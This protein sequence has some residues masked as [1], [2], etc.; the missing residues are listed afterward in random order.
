LVAVSGGADSTACLHA[1]HLLRGRFA[2]ELF[3][4]GVDH[5]LRPAATDELDHAEL[6]SQSLAIPFSRTVVAVAPGGDLHRRA[7]DAR[8][9]A[10]EAAAAA[11]GAVAIATA[12]HRDDRAETVL[13]RLLHGAHLEGLGVLPL[14][15]GN[16]FR[17]LIDA[18]RADVLAHCA[19]H[20]LR[21]AEDPSNHNRRFLRARL[22]AEVLP[23]LREISPQ[24]DAHLAALADDVCRRISVSSASDS[25]L[26]A[27]ARRRIAQA[28]AGG[29][30]TV[31]LLLDGG[32]PAT[33][34]I[35]G[36]AEKIHHRPRKRRE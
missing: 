10:L 9:A 7:R 29:A 18:S 34:V 19:R 30:K 32:V 14:R 36:E 22:R 4:H 17:P 6:L 35:G 25:L 20:Q 8:Y 15:D 21:F 24:I 11:V 3:A 5:G 1:L 28:V 23:L 16:R 13:E 33:V 26:T 31:P 27:G 12:H 2:I